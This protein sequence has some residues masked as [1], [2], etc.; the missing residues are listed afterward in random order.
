[1]AA[2]AKKVK[3]TEACIMLLVA[4][5]ETSETSKIELFLKIEAVNY[6]H[7]RHHLNA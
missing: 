3:L 6:F 4:F 1:M 2:E 5:L 7:K